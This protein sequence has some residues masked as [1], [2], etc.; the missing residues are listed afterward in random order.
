MKCQEILDKYHGNLNWLA[1]QTIVIVPHGSR[2][3]GT[4]GPDS[5]WDWKGVFIAPARYHLGF[6]NKIESLD[7]GFDGLDVAMYNL[8]FFF[9]KA[10]DANPS[11]L[12]MLFTDWNECLFNKWSDQLI[13]HDIYNHREKFLSKNCYYRFTGYAVSQ[14]KKIQSHR[15]WILDKPTHKPTR[16]EFGLPA[17]HSAIST[18][19]RDIW[20][21]LINSR[22]ESWR[23]DLASVDPGTRQMLLDKFE[24]VLK[25]MGQGTEDARWKTAAEHVGVPEHAFEYLKKE[26]QYKAASKRWTQFL[27]WQNNRN[28]ARSEM[29]RES[30]FDRKHGMHLVRLLNMG[31][32]IL[33]GQGVIT[34]RPDAELLKE[35]RF[36]T[37]WTYEMLMEYVNLKL[38]R[39]EIAFKNTKLPNQ[40]DKKFLDKLCTDLVGNYLLQTEAKHDLSSMDSNT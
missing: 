24:E 2:S 16:E 6:V 21:A 4:N 37:V 17:S 5:D 28:E 25:E 33:N 8:K 22:L 35:I 30:G 11:F 39:I 40:P 38:A 20:E 9:D 34:K 26:R 10:C 15:G 19:E 1:K 31:E 12:E 14:L 23:P 36:T 29:E 13:W 7:K 3:Y 18:D 27:D 32:E